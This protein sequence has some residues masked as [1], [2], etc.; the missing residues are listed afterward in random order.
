MSHN[1]YLL[2]YVSVSLSDEGK[3]VHTWGHEVVSDP[4]GWLRSVQDFEG[5]TYFIINILPISDRDFM[6]LSVK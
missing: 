3:I 4:I 5:E 2:T 6:R 1:K